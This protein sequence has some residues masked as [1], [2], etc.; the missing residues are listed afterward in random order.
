MIASAILIPAKVQSHKL[1]HNK[2]QEISS[3]HRG[4]TVLCRLP[5]I[6]CSDSIWKGVFDKL[7]N[8][9]SLL[10]KCSGYSG[11]PRTTSRAHLCFGFGIVPKSFGIAAFDIE[12]RG[13][14]LEVFLWT[15]L[16]IRLDALGNGSCLASAGC[17]SQ[18]T[19]VS[20]VAQFWGWPCRCVWV[21]RGL[22]KGFSLTPGQHKPPFFFFDLIHV[23]RNLSGQ[24]WNPHR[25]S[26]N[27]RSLTLLSHQ[28][29]P[30][31]IFFWCSWEHLFFF[32]FFAF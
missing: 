18:V 17:R 31:T 7:V 1:G 22:R 12:G 11:H 21:K 19:E 20:P 26:D 10:P 6:C 16:I 2:K 30:Y 25:S 28:G 15:A 23:M 32:F 29:T 3:Q 27:A 9:S 13:Q 14:D 5:R 24:G 8:L 4:E